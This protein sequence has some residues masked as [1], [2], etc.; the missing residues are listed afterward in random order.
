[1]FS[2]LKKSFHYQIRK[3]HRYLGLFIGIQ[4]FLWTAG[5]LYFSWTNLD[6]I[7]GDHLHKN[8]PLLPV[9]LPEINSTRIVE[10]LK[11]AGADSIRAFSLIELNGQILAR[12]RYLLPDGSGDTRLFDAVSG[13]ER[14]P[15]NRREAIRMAKSLIIPPAEPVKVEYLTQTGPHHEYREKPLPA[16]AIS[17]DTDDAP[18]IYIAAREGSYSTIRHTGWRYFDFLWMLH[19]MDYAERDDFNNT[20]LRIFS[21]LGLITILSGFVLFYISSPVIRRKRKKERAGNERS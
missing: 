2:L 5:G 18:T 8:P 1:M 13:N 3:Y 15:I 17:F 7:H 9:N 10:Q 14:P 21:V 4:F 6:D 16:W 20:L 11:Q 12:V 19:T